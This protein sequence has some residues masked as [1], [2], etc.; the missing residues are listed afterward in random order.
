MDFLAVEK[1]ASDVPFEVVFVL[2]GVVLLVWCVAGC[3][4]RQVN[5]IVQVGMRVIVSAAIMFALFYLARRHAALSSED[6]W[7]QLKAIFA[8]A[9]QEALQALQ[10]C[11]ATLLS[12]FSAEKQDL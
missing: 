3:I 9:H 11:K 4:V 5:V 12:T 10:W 2:T 1:G 6:N 8:N 7:A